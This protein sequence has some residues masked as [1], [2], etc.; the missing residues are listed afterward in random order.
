L[1][2]LLLVRA[3]AVVPAEQIID[4]LW[5]EAPPPNAGATLHVRISELRRALRGDE[6]GAA[7]VVETRHSGYLL[8]TAPDAVDAHRFERLATRGR[9]ELAAGDAGAAAVT[10]H[11]AL[12]LW[13]D[14]PLPEVAGRPFAAAEVMRLEGLRLQALEDRVEAELALGRHAGLLVELRGLVTEFPLHERYWRQLML[15]EYRAGRQADAL[16]AYQA[17]RTLLRDELGLDPGPELQRLRAAI[18]AQDPALDLPVP[19]AAGRSGRTNLPLSLTSFI[20]RAREMREVR[21]RLDASRLV[22][23]TG[24]GGVGKSRLALEVA[25]AWRGTH[26]GGTWL[27]E[28]AKLTQ[29]GLVMGVVART[30]GVLEHPQRSFVDQVAD[31]VGNSE[32][33]LLLDNC[34]HLVAEVA[35]V[36][37][38]LLAA[39]PG[40]QILATSRERLGI[41]GEVL[42]L[43]S[44]LSVPDAGARSVAEVGASEAVQLLVERIAAVQQGTELEEATVAALAEGS[45]YLEGLPLAI[46]LAAAR[47]NAFDLTQIADRLQDRF[48][49]LSAGTRSE[50]PRHQTLRAVVDWS[51]ELLTQAERR[52]FARASVFVGGFTLEAAEAVCAETGPEDESVAVLV[53]RLIDKSLL[54]VKPAESG[55]RYDMLET[56]RMYGQERLVERGEADLLRDRHTEF[57][58]TLAETAAP[59]LRGPEQPIWLQRLETEHANLR[60]ALEWSTTQARRGR[61]R[62]TEIAQRLAGAI[63]QMWDLHGHYGEGRR[64]LDAALALPGPVPDVVRARVLVGAANL[65][66]IQGDLEKGLAACEQA[67]TLFRNAGAPAGLAHALQYLGLGA[68]YAGELERATALLEES[69]R[70]AW[71]AEDAWTEGWA[72]VFLAVTDLALAQF[73]RAAELIA[74]CQSLL[75]GGGDPECLA[76]AWAIR[77]AAAWWLGDHETAARATGEAVRAFDRL[78]GVWGMATS[79]FLAANVAGTAGAHLEQA[80]LLGA[81]ERLRESAGAATLPFIASWLDE[82]VATATVA[83]GPEAFQQAYDEGGVLAP[84]AAV[85]L[86]MRRVADAVSRI[87]VT[88]D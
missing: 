84:D 14:S 62:Y 4:A 71:A 51:H 46:E 55:R 26:E 20:G 17:A 59:A 39:C 65:A 1:L 10:L 73:G 41:P 80:V 22:T 11:D 87:P 18:L 44:G 78:G 79:L 19:A 75:R 56:L 42:Y 27:V 74:R 30:L 81:S 68:V 54:V 13:R 50:L 57:F 70:H 25:H 6:A 45:R 67:A 16:D 38:E 66:V 47:A 31:H 23:L 9:T 86:A 15:A 63:Y 7:S 34:E 21:A 43:I 12:A 24:V 29:S 49:L 32:V 58:L 33:L 60:A 77:G 8:R 53:A 37:R 61:L 72:L 48:R 85:A 36:A 82:T 5:G 3:G 35:E 2:L 64:R 69:M 88:A 40:L 83:L 76:W 28:L 52:L